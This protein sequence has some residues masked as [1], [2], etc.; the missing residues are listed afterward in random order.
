MQLCG[1]GNRR[2]W[3]RRLLLSEA[4]GQAGAVG[5]PRPAGGEEAT[6]QGATKGRASLRHDRR[7]H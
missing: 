7:H 2:V 4:V 5:R 1:S 3:R 6:G